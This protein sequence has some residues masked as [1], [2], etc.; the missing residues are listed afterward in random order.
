[1]APPKPP[2]F[3]NYKSLNTEKLL[4]TIAFGSC[5]K[6]D[7]PQPI[8]ESVIQN[9][10]DLWIWLGDIIYGDTENME[11]LK[12]KYDAQKSNIEYQK[13]VETCPV[14]G[15]WDDHDYGTNDGDKNYSKKEESKQLLLNFLDVSNKSP[16]RKREGAYQSFTFGKKDKKV[17]IILLDGR[18][19][20]DELKKDNSQ[21][22]RYLP[23]ETGDVLGEAQC[24]G[25]RKSFPILPLC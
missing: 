18:Y 12:K 21:K 11:T 7:L 6:H 24:N 22:K 10:P 5:N 15:I 13:L 2:T 16:V 14:I 9:Q 1:M 23:N 8:W 25:C 19:F 3:V 4:T 17:K 20:R